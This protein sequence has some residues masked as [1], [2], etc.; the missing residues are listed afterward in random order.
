MG[1]LY[2]ILIA[3]FLLLP[4]AARAEGGILFFD[5]T[6]ASGGTSVYRV[7]PDGSGL[8]EIFKSGMYPQWS[9]DGTMIAMLNIASESNIPLVITDGMGKTLHRVPGKFDLQSAY[10]CSHAWSP[11]NRYV[12]FTSANFLRRQLHLELY[13]LEK[14]KRETLYEIPV[15]DLDTA[16]VNQI[17]WTSEGKNIVFAAQVGDEDTAVGIYNLDKREGEIILKGGM[18]S[19]AWGEERI[20]F[21]TRNGEIHTFWTLDLRKQK[22]EKLLELTGLLDPISEIVGNKVIIRGVVQGI[23]GFFIL[24]LT[25]KEPKKL[26]L[27]DY[28]M[29]SPIYSPDGK[30]LLFLAARKDDFLR[31]EGASIGYYVYDISLGDLT[32]L[33]KIEK[34]RS[35]SYWMSVYM[36]GRKE[37]SWR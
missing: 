11:D 14:K 5:S 20:F 2:L 31:G 32:L 8:K 18:H 23:R 27:H 1:N 24:D 30:R 29:S 28:L 12:A 15:R 37:Y 3:M 21:V 9:A 33:R 19:R 26:D 36:G 4:Q 34:K 7:S 10:I 6:D 13:E 17:S 22:R 35:R 25:L 16:C